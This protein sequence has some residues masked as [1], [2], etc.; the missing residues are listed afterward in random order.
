MPKNEGGKSGHRFAASRD[1]D[2]L[3]KALEVSVERKEGSAFFTLTARDV[4]HA[5]PT[6]DLFRRLV[7]RLRT[8]H[9]VLEQPL[10]RNFGAARGVRYEASDLRLQPKRHFGLPLGIGS[11]ATWE[12][13]YQRV[14]AVAQAPPFTS[15][16]EAE[17]VLAR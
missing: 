10:S 9:G 6:G 16:V 2:F 8:E 4:G 5:F 17:L 12:V 7:V 13:A 3:A 1:R 15:T 14:T 11:A